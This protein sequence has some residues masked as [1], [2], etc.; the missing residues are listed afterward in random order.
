[1][2]RAILITLQVL[3]GFI[4]GVLA[5]LIWK[6]WL[7]FYTM[8]S[9]DVSRIRAT[10]IAVSLVLLTLAQYATYSLRRCISK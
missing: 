9:Y 8:V 6:R 1:M 4:L 5:I 3:V 2:K 10:G 7:L